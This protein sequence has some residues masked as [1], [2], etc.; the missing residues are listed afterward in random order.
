LKRSVS[1]PAFLRPYRRPSARDVIIVASSHGQ[2]G[3]GESV[4]PTVGHL[5]VV[6]CAI[7]DLLSAKIHDA[8]NQGRAVREN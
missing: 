4:T 5:P 7:I 2:Q 3:C 8:S 1:L 6:D